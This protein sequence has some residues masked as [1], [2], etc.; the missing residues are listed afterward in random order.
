MNRIFG[1]FGFNQLP[2]QPLSPRQ[3]PD[4]VSSF[5]NQRDEHYHS[6]F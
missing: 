2:S 6:W 4:S 5:R 3:S 1:R